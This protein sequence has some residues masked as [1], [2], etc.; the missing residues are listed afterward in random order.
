MRSDGAIFKVMPKLYQ[1]APKLQSLGSIHTCSLWACGEPLSHKEDMQS[2]CSRRTTDGTS[3]RYFQ[4]LL[5]IPDWALTADTSHCSVVELPRVWRRPCAVPLPLTGGETSDS[6]TAKGW[7][8]QW[9]H[10]WRYCAS[11]MYCIVGAYTDDAQPHLW[12]VRRSFSFLQSAYCRQHGKER[13]C[14]AG[15]SKKI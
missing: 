1:H 8:Y 13:V 6:A 10:R 11:V 15:K 7:R 4:F 2:A 5:S 14:G 3:E 9:R 12:A